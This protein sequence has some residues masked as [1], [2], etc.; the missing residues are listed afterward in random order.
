MPSCVFVRVQSFCVCSVVAGRHLG[1]N[2][3]RVCLV[4]VVADRLAEAVAELEGAGIEA[5]SVVT[6]VTDEASCE[7]AAAAVVCWACLAVCWALSDCASPPRPSV[8]PGVQVEKWGRIDVLVQSAGITGRTGIATHEVDAADFDKVMAVNTRGVFLM[9]KA[10]LP[11]MQAQND[12]KG[13]CSWVLPP[14]RWPARFLT[15]PLLL[16]A[17]VATCR[18]RPDLQHCL[19]R[20]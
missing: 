14:C 16:V 10:V 20:W 7:A 17:R 12:G 3:H 8:H 1:G 15:V 18:L 2:H 19:H 9:A 13:V 6:D 4:D 5:M 11:T